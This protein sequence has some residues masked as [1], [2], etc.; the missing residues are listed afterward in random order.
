MNK[1]TDRN[2]LTQLGITSDEF[3]LITVLFTVPYIVAEI[4][5]N[6]LVKKFRPSRWQ[7]RIMLSWYVPNLIPNGLSRS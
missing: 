6:L 2:I 3:G 1:G 7:S 4:P 5:S